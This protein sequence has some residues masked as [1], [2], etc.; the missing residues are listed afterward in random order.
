VLGFAAALSMVTAVLFGMLPVWRG[1][2]IAAE[3]ALSLVL[4]AGAGL[5]VSFLQL[6]SVPPRL[7]TPC[8]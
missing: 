3:V 6:L 1:I 4:V 8:P 5:L 7:C 2:L